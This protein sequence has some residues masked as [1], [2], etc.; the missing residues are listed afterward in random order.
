MHRQTEDGVGEA[1][2]DREV[3]T[4]G[5]REAAVGG[6]VRNEGIEVAAPKNVNGFHV[7]VKLVAGAPILLRVHEDREI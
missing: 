3:L 5:G 2:C 6:E 4:G 7:E 1:V